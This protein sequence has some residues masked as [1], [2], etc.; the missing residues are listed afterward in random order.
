M[1]TAKALI[2]FKRNASFKT[3]ENRYKRSFIHE[4]YLEPLL[5]KMCGYEIIYVLH[6]NKAGGTSFF[7]GI[8]RMRSRSNKVKL[9]T[10]THKFGIPN[11]PKRSKVALVIRS[12]ETRYASGFEHQFRKGYPDYNA[13][14]SPQETL[15]FKEF[16]SFDQLV[17]GMNSKSVEKKALA[18]SAWKHIAHL[19]NSYR[20]YLGSVTFLENNL[21][22]IVFIG[23]QEKLNED[24]QTF[25]EAFFRSDEGVSIGKRNAL[26]TQRTIKESHTKAIASVYPDEFLL[27]AIL[28]NRKEQLLK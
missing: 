17:D 20:H 1:I 27:Y 14:W 15:I 24:W 10:M 9:I 12:P 21:D 18:E 11:L 4:L 7:E 13:S 28:K 5:S 8:H 3:W 6:I 26:G 25:C 2:F 19:S 22:R 16:K 23:E